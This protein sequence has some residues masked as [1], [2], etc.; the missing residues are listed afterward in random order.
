MSRTDI[1]LAT[2]QSEPYLEPL[3]ESL[4]SQTQA[5]FRLIVSDDCSTDG[6]LALLETWRPRFRDLTIIRRAQP[7][8]SAKANFS[9]LLEQSDADYTLF[10]DA[11]DVWDPD[12]VEVTVA[13][14]RNG[15]RRD[16][17]QVARYAF[18]DARIIDSNGQV[19]GSS[20]WAYKRL[21]PQTAD[22]VAGAIVCPPML[23]CTSGINR[24]L[25]E[26]A[27]PVPFERVTGHDWWLFLV[28]K[29]LGR[30]DVINRQT[31]S[32]R[33]HGNNSSNQRKVDLFQ[34]MVQDSKIKRVRRGIDQRQ[35]QAKAILDL[36]GPMLDARNREIL[37]GFC[38]LGG[39]DFFS[40]RAFL[41][42][43]RILYPDLARNL[44][45]LVAV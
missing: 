41:L 11:D 19:T 16:G 10:A 25:R 7:S 3:L 21:R 13:A 37:D 26:L 8:G 12:K 1:L 5:D 23:G 28:A 4:A 22:P 44:A 40:R 34:Y 31:L 32:Y 15:E 27:T 36:V 24:S 35:M 17:R 39:M 6:T 30:I 38:A 43:N 42:R 2:Y 33:I 29:C 45:M 9:F 14:L 18:S 20:F